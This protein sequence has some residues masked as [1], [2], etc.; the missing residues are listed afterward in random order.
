[1][2]ITK[3]IFFSVNIDYPKLTCPFNIAF[4]EKSVSTNVAGLGTTYDVTSGDDYELLIDS[5]NNAD[6]S[7]LH[8]FK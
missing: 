1:M 2:F 4:I 6:R 7:L 8:S 5:F 3:N